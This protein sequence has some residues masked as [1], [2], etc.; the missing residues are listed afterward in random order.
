MR[1]PLYL[2]LGAASLLCLLLMQDASNAQGTVLW[3]ADHEEGGEAD[4]NSPHTGSYSG[5]E[6]NSG[7]AGASPVHGFGRNPSGEDSWPFSLSL[8]IATPC[9]NLTQSGARMFRFREP[10]QHP[11]LYY[12]AWYYFPNLFTLTD[13]VNPFWIIMAWKS[14]STTPTRDDPFFSVNIHN[15]PD[16]QMA[17]SLYEYTPYDPSQTRNREQTLIDVPVAQWF[18]IEAYYESRGNASGRVTVWQGGEESRV[19][20]WDLQGVQ[21]RYPDVEGG[22]TA[23]AVTNYSNGIVPLPAQFAIDDA[24]IRTP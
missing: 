6:F 9:G 11:N 20:L 14:T 23:W 19:L 1:W 22:D 18:Y 5:G 8:T 13:P 4:W 15:R 10:L 3:S 12:R 7:C 16:G 17:L 2:L 21:T 24:E